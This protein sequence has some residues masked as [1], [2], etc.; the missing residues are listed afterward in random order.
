MADNKFLDRSGLQTLWTQID[1]NFARARRDSAQNYSASFV[2]ANREICFVDTAKKGLRAKIGD[3]VTAWSNLPYTDEYVLGQI[4]QVVLTGYYL[5]DKFYTDSTYTI[6]L[7]KATHK[8]YIDKNSS[9]LYH[10]N[11]EKYV[12]I[13][14][15]L[16]T[17]S[18]SLAGIVK[19]Y[20]QK[21]QNTDG[22]MSQKAVTD[23]VSSISFAVDED[24]AECLVL[25][26]PWE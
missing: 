14:E 2:P 22:A 11:G 24:D 3:G 21:G 6:E 8:I 25:E 12:S 1:G 5:N 16:P 4:E 9:V 26:L 20:Q 23:G 7:E 17:A 19:L 10:Y 18:E 15:T 13:N